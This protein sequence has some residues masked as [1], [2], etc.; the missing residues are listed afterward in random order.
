MPTTLGGHGTRAV[1]LRFNIL[2]RMTRA[3]TIIVFAQLLGTSSWF[4][5]N[6]AAS[7]L[8]VRWGL[9]DF[10][11]GLLLTS[12]QFGF[13]AGTLGISLT[14][15]AD[16]FRASRIF[17][18][19]ALLAALANAAFALLSDDIGVATAFRFATGLA[20]AGVYPLGMKLVVGWAPKQK[21]AALGWLVGALTLGTA[22]PHLLRALGQSWPWQVIVLTSSALAL[23]AGVMIFALGDGPSQ[24]AP[25][26]PNWGGV[27][28]VFRRPAFRASAL[29]YFG[30]MWEL[31]AFWF[32]VPQ[33]VG[34]IVSDPFTRSLASFAVIGVGGLGCVLGGLASRRI[35]SERVAAAALVISSVCC[36]VFPFL[37]DAPPELRLLLLL[38]WGFAVVADSPQF[39]ALSARA[40]PP[41]TVGAALAVQNGI[42]FAI[43]VAAI[44]LSAWQW[45][46]LGSRSAWLLAPGPVI[47]LLA[48]WPLLRQRDEATAL[49]ASRYQ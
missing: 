10:E 26:P 41:E 40:C 4:S 8:A 38:I 11:R 36:V 35:G 27:L 33:L 5:G 47:G 34:S 48:M 13:I 6:V 12:V 44:Q 16:A 31:Y 1:K 7:E 43:T 18:A 9:G 20:L 28:G 23:I 39:S 32:L 30:H 45:P 19:S 29:G 14:G 22:S 17:A 37:G 3:L 46:E 21:G 2:T 49:G 15:L 24:P 42:G 25:V